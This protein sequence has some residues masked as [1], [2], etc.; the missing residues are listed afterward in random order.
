M[1]RQKVRIEAHGLVELLTSYGGRAAPSPLAPVLTSVPTVNASPQRWRYC[2][3]N[4]WRSCGL[5]IR[6]ALPGPRPL[7][8]ARA[9]RTLR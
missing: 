9:V 1:A 4:E 7:S 6:P 2:F 8:A 3:A 5:G